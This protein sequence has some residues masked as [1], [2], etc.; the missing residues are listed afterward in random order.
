MNRAD[1]RLQPIDGLVL[2]RLDRGA[3]QLL[4]EK[5]NHLVCDRLTL[6]LYVQY[7]ANETQGLAGRVCKD[8][9][10]GIIGNFLKR[11]GEIIAFLEDVLKACHYQPF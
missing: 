5:L 4:C 1:V 3:L 11:M 2:Y 7:R 6:F 9:T 8:S 10:V